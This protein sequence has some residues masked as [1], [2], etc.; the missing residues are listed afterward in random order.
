MKEKRVI[1]LG[2]FDGIHLG[3]KALIRRCQELAGGLGC[4]ASV[5]TFT[6]HPDALVLRKEPRLINTLYLRRK[7]LGQY[8]IRDVIEL[9]FDLEMMAM[10]WDVFLDMLV[11]DYCAAGMVCGHD[12]RFGRG[13]AGNAAELERYCQEHGLACAVVPE[14]KLDGI[15][16]SST[17]IR[18]LVEQG[19]VEEA[20]RFLGHHH[21][22]E[23]TVISGHQLGRKLGMPT[24]NIP[25]PEGVVCP[26][27]G[28]YASRVAVDNN[29]YM[30]VT[31]VG[32][33]PT[34]DGEGLTVETLLLNFDGD[35]YGKEIVVSLRKF[36]R[37]EHRFDSLE[38]LR[39]AVEKDKEDAFYYFVD[40]MASGRKIPDLF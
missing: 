10:E 37:P 34:V 31:N 25:L 18:A 3:H 15:P 16:V 13:G 20:E 2:F 32:R 30:A 29:A 17:H 40:L 26:A 9:P 7:I 38:E 1:A 33:R 19:R 28:V 12:F 23:G 8:G 14:Q 6:S 36:L 39:R 35:L 21:C 4:A 5:L 11:R 22:L 27:L 24:A